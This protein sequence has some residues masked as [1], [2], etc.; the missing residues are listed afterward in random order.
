MKK[1]VTVCEKIIN[2]FTYLGIASLFFLM[3]F[4]V[5]NIILRRFFNMPI[6]GS[7]ELT[8]QALVCVI[9]FG[10]AYCALDDGMMSVDILQ[11]P[12]GYTKF[13]E[14]ITFFVCIASGAASLSSANTA[15]YTKSLTTQL[16]IPKCIFQ[17]V[18]TAGYFVLALA[19]VAIFCR[20][21]IKKE[22]S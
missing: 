16:G 22:G 10:M 20:D 7:V 8:Q 15:R 2:A 1:I 11:V 14:I 19:V 13:L 5:V 6:T 17:Y 4:T 21:F 18:L 9:W 3:M 12:K